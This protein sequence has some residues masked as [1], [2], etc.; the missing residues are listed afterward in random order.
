METVVD[1]YEKFERDA[2]ALESWLTGAE[3]RLSIISAGSDTSLP[4][5]QQRMHQL[6]EL[7]ADADRQQALRTRVSSTAAQL[8]RHR[9][10]DAAVHARAHAL[11]SRWISLMYKVESGSENDDYATCAVLIIRYSRCIDIWNW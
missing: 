10:Q 11:D 3:D 8:Q 9:P 2:S 4:V 5:I 1:Q 7:R 6:A